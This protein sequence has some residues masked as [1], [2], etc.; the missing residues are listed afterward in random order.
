M[1]T[2]DLNLSKAAMDIDHASQWVIRIWFPNLDRIVPV[3]FQCS[4]QLV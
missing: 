2:D 1:K 4:G 3:L